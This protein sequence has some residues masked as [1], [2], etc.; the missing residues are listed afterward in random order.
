MDR[1]IQRD[2]EMG[3]CSIWYSIETEFSQTCYS[4]RQT[5]T[6]SGQW[7]C[8]L[9]PHIDKGFTKK[10]NA[11][12]HVQTTHLNFKYKCMRCQ[13]I[14]NRKEDHRCPKRGRLKEII[15]FNTISNIEDSFNMKHFIVIR[16]AFIPAFLLSVLFI[17]GN[18]DAQTCAECHFIGQDGV[19]RCNNVI[20]HNPAGATP[21]EIR[22]CVFM[23][24]HR[25]TFVHK[26]WSFVKHLSFVRI[27]NGTKGQYVYFHSNWHAGINVLS[28]LDIHLSDGRMG[29][30]DDAFHGMSTLNILELSSL[31]YL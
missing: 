16:D 17:A 29:F 30:D 24:I 3:R 14:I 20:P 6:L 25:G 28:R 5:K 7:Q 22:L 4:S 19:L 10:A 8:T 18:V 23:D 2:K 11:Q 15:L 1:P 27:S 13:A 21:V 9:C 26:N 31:K 12:R